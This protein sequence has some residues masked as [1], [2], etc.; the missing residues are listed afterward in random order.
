LRL[1]RSSLLLWLVVCLLL[2]LV[3]L[4]VTGRLGKSRHGYAS[5]AAQSNPV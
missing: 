5:A 1:S 3:W 2:F 4:T